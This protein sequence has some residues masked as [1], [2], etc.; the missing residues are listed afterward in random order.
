[1]SALKICSLVGL[2]SLGLWQ[3]AVAGASMSAAVPYP[4]ADTPRAIDVGALDARA[5]ATAIS[6]TVALALTDLDAAEKL[7]RSLNTP[8]D[9]QYHKF[10]TAQEFTA[11][12]APSKSEVARVSAALGKYGLTVEQASATTLRVTGLPAAMERAFAVSLRSY[13]VPAHGG[14]SGYTYHAPLAHSTIPAEIASSV[15]A[16]IGLDNRPSLRPLSLHAP[17][18]QADNSRPAA[19]STLDA[20]GS[21]TVQDFA[22][23]YD[24]NPLYKRGVTGQGRTL[25]I[26]SL[27]NFTPSD[28]FAY[29]S[30]LGL[31]VNPNRL[32]IVYVDQ[33]PGAPSDISGSLETTIDIEQ[34]G[35]IAPGANIIAYLAPNTNQAFTDVFA[36]AIEANQAETLSISW[37]GWEWFDTIEN[38][39][40]TDP[41]TGRT[42]SSLQAIHE[43]LVR[44]AI[45]GQS[46]FTAE[47]D[48]GAYEA[49]ADLGC[50]GP[51]SSS[52]PGSC[53]NTL[54]V[55]YPG[56]DP[57]ITS[58]GGTT[59]PGTI[60]LCADSACASPYFVNI[61][62]ERVWGWDYQ[63]G[64]CAAQ[65]TP[66][67]IACQIFPVGGGGGVSVFFYQPWYQFGVP[68]VQLSQPGQAFITGPEIVEED[69]LA[70]GYFAL[71]AFF[72]GRN[73]PD[74][75]FNADPYTGY[76]V[77]YTSN[78]SGYGEQTGWG[79]TSFVAPQLN[80]VSALYGQY[81]H[82]RLGLLNGAFYAAANPWQQPASLRPIAYGDNWFYRGSDGYNPGA[83]LGTLD[84]ANF[85]EY[86]LNPY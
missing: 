77:F 2:F 42:V 33:G 68:G 84:V 28:V 53:S 65:G 12:F 10:L 74:V 16:V 51:Y 30:A 15:T 35:G 78:V 39:P 86:L 79:G 52:Q 14:A 54:S 61:P 36:A 60:K 80:G 47:G 81:L 18:A 73:V 41:T 5:P 67:P 64:F 31:E 46:V 62:H 56:T 17:L 75:S 83:G 70:S 38:A 22:K 48:G 85:A 57:A 19:G 71:P 45:Q 26:M 4:S 63:L 49:N 72:P 66:S 50:F 9:A 32:Q 55:G 25:G 76:V 43:L 13:E 6:V 27:A 24:V 21:L 69:G 34:S 44:A 58:A 37:G 7:L 3:G 1:M 40:V 20:F 82:G 11:R 29:W 8:G 59:L 23:L